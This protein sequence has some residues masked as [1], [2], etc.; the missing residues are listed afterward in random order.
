M[1][2]LLT[3]FTP[4][5]ICSS[6]RSGRN[7]ACE[8]C[9]KE[10]FNTSHLPGLL[11]L[12]QYRGNLEQAVLALK[13]RGV[14]R[15]SLPLAGELAR[16]V[17]LRGWQPQALSCVPLHA[18]RQRERG[19]NQAELLARQA[20]VMLDLPFLQLLERTRATRRQAS[21]PG[22][23]RKA[24]TAAAFAVSARA[25][26]VLPQRVLLIDDVLTTGATIDACRAALLQAGVAQVLVAVVALAAP[27]RST[28]RPAGSDA[29]EDAGGNAEDAA[30]QHLGVGVAQE[31]LQ[32]QWPEALVKKMRKFTD[33][34]IDQFSLFA[35]RTADSR[36]VV[37][38]D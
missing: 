23:A 24:N 28:P 5:S 9:L 7:G 31:R 3:S 13:F 18:G 26:R 16:Q 1:H 36:G 35:G 33:Q 34:V 14:Q 12:G 27:Q 30:H 29:D 22:A 32:D 15:L 20:A 37:H 6:A 11:A 10:L 38:D 19:Y 8:D 17:K 21:L 4:C 25:P 2:R